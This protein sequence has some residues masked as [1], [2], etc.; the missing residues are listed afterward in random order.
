MYSSHTTVFIMYIYKLIISTQT[1]KLYMTVLC[2]KTFTLNRY[3]LILNSNNWTVRILEQLTNS[4][5]TNTLS[6]IDSTSFKSYGIN[7]IYRQTQW[8]KELKKNKKYYLI[9]GCNRSRHL[10]LYQVC[11]SYKSLYVGP[12]YCRKWLSSLGN[13]SP[14]FVDI[15]IYH[16]T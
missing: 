4:N 11:S 14:Y 7:S 8:Q 2:S 5:K 9:P 15:T 6:E 13:I 12:V 10:T 3:E 1:G 16:H